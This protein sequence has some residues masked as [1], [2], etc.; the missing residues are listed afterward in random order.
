MTECPNCDFLDMQM[1]VS[2]FP[3]TCKNCGARIEPKTYAKTLV[4]NAAK[5][6]ETQSKVRSILKKRFLQQEEKR[7][8]IAENTNVT[9][10]FT[11]QSDEDP[12]LSL[13][14]KH[15]HVEG[16][17]TVSVSEDGENWVNFPAAFFSEVTQ[18]LSQQRVVRPSVQP[19][20]SPLRTS[21][22]PGSEPGQ[23][24]ITVEDANRPQTG[25]PLP[26]IQ[27]TTDN[28]GTLEPMAVADISPIENFSAI[29]ALAS[30]VSINKSTG[31]RKQR[32]KAAEEEVINRPVIRGV[33]EQ[34]A[35]SLRGANEGKAIR[36]NHRS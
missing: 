26:M 15:H 2:F 32:Q 19:K 7:M 24:M 5:L 25:L 20:R 14:V 34:T 33:D 18:F 6:K 22:L 9:I 1:E 17:A 27:R 12:S 8:A 23:A 28:N 31:V 3:R 21:V 4:E 11:W 13:L 35:K 10:E 16:V 29:E 30:R 36:S